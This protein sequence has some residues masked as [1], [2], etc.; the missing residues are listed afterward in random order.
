[1]TIAVDILEYR[2]ERIQLHVRVRRADEGPP[3][4]ALWLRPRGADELV[5]P[6]HAEVAEGDVFARFNVMQGPGRLPLDPGAWEIVGSVGDEAPVTLAA[7]SGRID[8]ATATARFQLG[9]GEYRAELVLR[10]DAAL[11]LEVVLDP[12]IRRP[13]PPMTATRFVKRH[14]K[15]VLRP[16]RRAVFR[17]IFIAAG[18]T[19]PRGRRRILFTSDSND[20]LSGNLKLVYDRMVERGVDREYDLRTLLRARARHGRGI[21]HRLRLPAA[22]GRADIVV[23]DDYHPLVYTL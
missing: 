18:A 5:P 9:R 8:A 19:R 14:V 15:R 16:V 12:S 11:T 20:T 4:A 23:L 17:L 7:P 1:M 21:R 2:W 3:L 22:L 6:A 13:P 10:D